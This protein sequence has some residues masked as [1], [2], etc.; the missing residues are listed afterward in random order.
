MMSSPASE[1]G[2]KEDEG[3]QRRVTLRSPLTVGRFEVTFAEWD[4]CVSAG[5]CSHRPSD[6]G[7]DRGTRPVIDV[8]W[9]HA[10][11]YVRWLS[12]RTG[13][14]Y[15]L[16]TEA[17]WEY[18]ARAGTTTPWHT[19]ASIGPSQAVFG[20][21]RT[22][23]VGSRPANQF[24]L[25]DMHGNVWEWVEDCYLESYADAPLDASQAVTSPDCGTRVLR[26]GS[27]LFSSPQ[28]LRSAD[29]FRLA[30]GD[31]FDFIGFRVARTPGG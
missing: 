22:E 10:Q 27:W 15:R 11:A 4:A 28:D 6:E 16:L 29:R 5:G 20:T 19:G 21:S 3:P 23:P 26:G 12:R 18:A 30:P 8:S 17:E 31:R 25:H 1:Q 13:Q 24:G 7:W 9:E 2:R 14:R